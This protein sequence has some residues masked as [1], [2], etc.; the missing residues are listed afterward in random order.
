MKIYHSFNVTDRRSLSLIEAYNV[1]NEILLDLADTLEDY[2]KHYELH[3]RDITL[4]L[5]NVKI[6]HFDI[7]D[8][9][10]SSLKH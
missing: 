10:I 2:P 5:N 4:D 7:L 8:T 1:A 6:Y 3:L 9:K